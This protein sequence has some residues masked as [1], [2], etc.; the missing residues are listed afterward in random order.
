MGKVLTRFELTKIALQANCLQP[1]Q[2]TP[3]QVFSDVPQDNSEMSLII[4]TAQS[5]GIVTG[6]D[7]K[8]YPNQAVTYAEMSKILLGSGYY[9]QSQTA[10]VAYSSSFPGITDQSF[11]QYAEYAVRLQLVALN[12]GIFPQNAPIYRDTMLQVLSRYISYLKNISLS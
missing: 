8:F 2:L 3:N 12:N 11:S 10:P 9:F 1:N 4:G 5:L 6:K 7:G